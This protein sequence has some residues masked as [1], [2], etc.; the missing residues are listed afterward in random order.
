M[1]KLKLLAFPLSIIVIAIVIIVIRHDTVRNTKDNNEADKTDT[2][3]YLRDGISMDSIKNKLSEI[4][5]NISSPVE[6]A[7]TI[8]SLQ[9]P[10][11]KNYLLDPNINNYNR[12]NAKAIVLGGIGVD[13][14]Y[15]C[16][17]EKKSQMITPIM[18]VRKLTNDLSISQFFDYE[19]IKQLLTNNSTKENV[20]SL[21]FLSTYNINKMQE[22]LQ[23][24]NR[25]RIGAFMTLG[26]WTEGISLITQAAI[27]HPGKAIY[28]RVG[29]QKF[30]MVELLKLLSLFEKDDDIKLVMSKMM[31]LKNKL[32]QVKIQYEDT[33]KPWKTVDIN[34][35]PVWYQWQKS[36]V[37]IDSLQVT[38]IAKETLLFR[39]FLFSLH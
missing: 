28:G 3:N 39:N 29:E 19:T 2:I 32:D 17:Y 13:L 12:N 22:F 14:L 35:K 23:S 1:N 33:G 9:I 7:A 5:C 37:I 16:Y 30:F 34:G 18:Q 21:R 36:I 38:S 27:D 26:G 15:L 31:P 25:A 24:S 11:S 10:F 6:V 4:A 20:D 8:K